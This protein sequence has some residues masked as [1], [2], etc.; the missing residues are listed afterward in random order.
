MKKGEKKINPVNVRLQVVR[1][2]QE[3]DTSGAYAN[4]LLKKYIDNVHF[5]DVDRR[6]FT[7]LFYGILRRE[8]YLDRIIE[9]LANR[10]VAKVNPLAL[11]ILRLGLYQI[12]FMDKVPVQAAVNESVKIAKKQIR[13]LDGF[14]NAILRNAD[15]KRETLTP[16]LLARDAKDFLSI[17]YNVPLWMITVFCED[18]SLKEVEGIFS[19]FNQPS[20]LTGRLNTLRGDELTIL[21]RLERYGVSV[22]KSEYFT[23]GCII[24]QTEGSLSQAPW[25]QDGLV[26]IMDEGSLAVA[27]ALRPQP[28]E[29][30]LDVCAAPGGK[31]FHMAA[32]MEN[33]GYIKA[34]DVIDA[35][36]SLMADN[37]KRLGVD[38][39]DIVK[40]DARE[41]PIEDYTS[42]D[43]VL[44]D[45]PCS[46][47]GVLQKKLDMRWNK[48]ESDIDILPHLQLTILSESAK[49]LRPGGYLVYSTC[50]LRKKENEDVVHK[51]L[52]LH[53]DFTL[54][55]FP[56]HFPFEASDGMLT[57]I[58]SQTH[59]DGFFMA[60]FMRLKD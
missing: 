35:R 30:I 56:E 44:V 10:K 52:E 8:N 17:K 31:T 47:L 39:V 9:T 60:R 40:Q 37:A 27:H 21:S 57:L 36:L 54:Q 38:N 5:T 12:F 50:T 25:I 42:Y 16:E 59:T 45:A 58:P 26:A 18:Y 51:F 15:R 28:N 24:T 33:T 6:F 11:Q 4:I 49:A 23:E 43:K 29:R 19:H 53:P 20:R 41:L 3:V 13:G 32:L 48:K 22:E 46:G 7:E 1:A 34:C 55:A 14:V 2:L